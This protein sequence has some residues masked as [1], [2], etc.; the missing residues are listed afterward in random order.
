[1]IGCKQCDELHCNQCD[2]HL[3][4]Y[5]GTDTEVLCEECYDDL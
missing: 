1:M 2:K 5:G 4:V 3:Q